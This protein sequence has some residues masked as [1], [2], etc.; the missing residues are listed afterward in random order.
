MRS[1]TWAGIGLPHQ[2]VLDLA[3]TLVSGEPLLTLKHR[4][5]WVR[6]AIA[7]APGTVAA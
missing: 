1:S 2:S 5:R 3:G 4:E 6:E 7:V